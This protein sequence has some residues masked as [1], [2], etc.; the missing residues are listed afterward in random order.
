[1]LGGDVSAPGVVLAQAAA[2]QALS[3]GQVLGFVLLDIFIILVAARAMGKLAS[4]IGQPRV[5][6]EIIAGVLL[7]PTLLGRTFF[8]WDT[9]FS[10]L[11][12]DAALA[13][14]GAD[15]SITNC[16]F[17]PQARGALGLLGQLALVLFMFLVGLELDWDLLKGK[18]KGIATVALGSVALPLILGF[19]I[20]PILYTSAFVAGFGSPEAPDQFGFTLFIAAMLTVTAFPV[21]ARILQEK[22][23][24]AS[25][26]GSI[27]VAAAAVVTVLMFLSVAVAAGVA[28]DQGPSSLVLKFAIA[29]V[30]VAVLF[31]VVRPALAPLDRAYE[32]NG[33]LTPGIFA[34]ILMLLF[35]SSY[36]AHQIGIN[37][38]VGGFLAGA[39]LPARKALFR[40]MASRLA[41]FTGVLLLPI[42][43]AFSGLGTDFT[44]LALSH[45]PGIA[46]FLVAGVVGKW[47]GGAAAARAGG[48]TWAEG[49]I[50]GILMN[51]RGLLILVVALI[52]VDQ[53]VIS[54][55]LQ[56]GGVLM[57][58]ITTMM[59]GPLFDAFIGRV[60]AAPAPEAPLPAAPPGTLRVLAGLDDLD[61]APAVASAAFGVVGDR[62]PAEVVLCRLIPLSANR[63][64][65]SGINDDPLEAE[66]SMRSLRILGTLAPAG[67]DVTPLAF[68]SIDQTA[69]LLRIAT[70]RSCDALVIGWR[71]SGRGRDSDAA[72]L[73]RDA[74]CPV[75]A[76][77]PGT[78][79]QSDPDGPVTVVG[80][81]EGDAMV[82]DMALHLAA[83]AGRTVRHVPFTDGDSL[84][85]AARRSSALVVSPSAAT[86]ADLHRDTAGVLS[87][88]ACPTYVVWRADEPARAAQP[89]PA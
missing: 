88:L 87:S 14:S 3:P 57:A 2:P 25:P 49:N 71:R 39:I 84:V 53:G 1:M 20:G 10:F 59:T 5:V 83:G 4:K 67:V 69:D 17:P 12:C 40:D 78:D 89:E 75:V 32:R 19:I 60:K 73:V 79:G 65:L 34:A 48:L 45:L 46:L 13:A 55:P 54:A 64:L 11:H 41:D 80:A 9:P 36:I 33:A 7:G 38:I 30:F 82:N 31:L 61:E 51:C 42:F 21:M 74:P 47:L 68:S 72:T 8:A 81:H 76:F 22:G 63:E 43:L 70:E 44:V 35:A 62:R 15:P 27:G 56:V 26:M 6:G 50:I 85:E 28:T 16:L 18:G 66:R 29:G 86:A 23:L 77:R 52:A 37:V 24:T 58:L